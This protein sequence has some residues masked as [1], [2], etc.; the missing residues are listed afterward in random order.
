MAGRFGEIVV[1]MHSNLFV[2]SLKFKVG[3]RYIFVMES[4]IVGDNISS[5]VSDSRIYVQKVSVFLTLKLKTPPLVF[6]AFRS[7]L[8]VE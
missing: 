6:C 5:T 2:N 8:K 7:H 4:I 3:E 1:M